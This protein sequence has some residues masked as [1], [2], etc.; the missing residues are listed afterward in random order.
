MFKKKQCF[1]VFLV[2]QWFGH[3]WSI[4]TAID[5]LDDPKA[6]RICPPNLRWL[7][8]SLE[9]QVLYCLKDALHSRPKCSNVLYFGGAKK[10][11]VELDF[12]GA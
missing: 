8:V 4:G 11:I 1:V 10:S 6:G 2:F 9:V 5:H 12:Y 3:V 7:Y